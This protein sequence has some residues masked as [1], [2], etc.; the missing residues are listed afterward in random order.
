MPACSAGEGRPRLEVADIFQVHGEAYRRTH[1]LTPQQA[2]ALRAIVSCRTAALGGHLEVCDHCGFSR[3]AYNSCRNRHCP[4]CQARAQ[5]GW[6]DRQVARILPT[7]YFHVVFTLPEELRGLVHRN[8]RVLFD[9]LFA[10]AARTLLLLGRD[11]LEA[12]LGLTAVLHTWTR[13]MAFHPHVHCIVSG[14]GLAAD[15]ASWSAT[16]QDY[17]FPHRVLSRLFRGKFLAGLLRLYHRGTL[18]LGGACTPLADPEVFR[19]FK[20][21]LYAKEW[22]VYAKPPFAGPQQVYRYL[23]RYT[24]RIAIS[25]ARLEAFEETGVRFR[26][27]H[28]RSVTLSSQEFIRRFLLHVLPEG[29]HK[30][31]HYG[32]LAAGRKRQLEQ[33]RRLL[34]PAADAPA[35]EFAA[36]EAS[37]QWMLRTAGI[38]LTRCPQCTVGT[39]VVRQLPDAVS[40]P[41]PL[42]LAS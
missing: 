23:G 11:H 31:R 38:D 40:R 32:L 8:R 9:L 39:M 42:P 18:D 41:P 19:L 24:H 26:T 28:G 34:A 10:A 4:K 27:R 21:R 29:F 22:V 13:E 3:P 5:A 30:I 25:N 36:P 2:R 37:T 20:S 1:V 16:R 14:G 17:L 33:A 12:T 6:V 7:H 35:P 15:G